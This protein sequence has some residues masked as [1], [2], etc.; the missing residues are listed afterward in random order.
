MIAA[1]VLLACAG[2]TPQEDEAPPVTIDLFQPDT[3]DV[4]PIAETTVGMRVLVEEF[5]IP[6]SDLAPLPVE[7]PGRADVLVRLLHRYP[8]GENRRYDLEITPFV[9][10]EID[11]RDHLVRL[12]G[13]DLDDVPPLIVLSEA[14]TD[15]A[16]EIVEPSGLEV[17]APRDVGG[18][19]TVGI[20]LGVLWVLGLLALLF[21][22][23]R[24]KADADDELEARPPTLA[25]RLHPLVHRASA[26]T[27]SGPERAEL[28]RLVVAHWRR[29]KGLEK[30]TAAEAM[31][32]LRS[33][34]DAAPL[35][36]RLEEWLHRPDPAPTS[37]TEVKELLAPFA[38][39]PAQSSGGYGA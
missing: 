35:L 22:G 18:Y 4:E 6:G 11:L 17:P 1:L 10:G 16:S 14:V 33:D 39:T 19:R 26:G 38:H 13:S 15:A 32:T 28:E 37:E 25:E 9:E 23:R 30:V 12:D 24:K 36:L 7:D 27:L 21:G 29:K 2:L 5:V 31:M 34:A 3:T 20:V 8:H